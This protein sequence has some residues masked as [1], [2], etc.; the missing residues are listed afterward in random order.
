MILVFSLPLHDKE[1]NENRIGHYLLQLYALNQEVY[2]RL[3]LF[4]VR[5]SRVSMIK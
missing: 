1:N 4:W 3:F 2:T 5:K